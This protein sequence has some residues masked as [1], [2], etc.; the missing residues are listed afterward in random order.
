MATPT[1]QQLI[2]MLVMVQHLWLSSSLPSF[3]GVPSHPRIGR[4]GL[5]IGDREE[6]CWP[7]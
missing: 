6:N 3:L 7:H 4:L 5:V 1:Y 2:Q